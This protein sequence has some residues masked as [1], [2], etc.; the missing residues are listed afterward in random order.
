MTTSK[1]NRDPTFSLADQR[2]FEA[3]AR[4][5]SRNATHWHPL[6]RDPTVGPPAGMLDIIEPPSDCTYKSIVHETSL[7]L[8]L[9]SKA[10]GSKM[11]KSEAKPSQVRMEGGD[12]SKTGFPRPSSRLV[13]LIGQWAGLPQL[14][15]HADGGGG[16]IGKD[17]AACGELKSGKC[18]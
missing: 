2:C 15:W 17:G 4:V 6:G 1:K 9:S 3:K 18:G 11:G 12:C 13:P 7:G 16:G 8:F 10:Y 5:A 14:E